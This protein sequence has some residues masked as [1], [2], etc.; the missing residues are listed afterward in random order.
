[1]LRVCGQRLG[2][3]RQPVKQLTR[4]LGVTGQPLHDAGAMQS[5][6]PASRLRPACHRAAELGEG[7]LPGLLLSGGD[8]RPRVHRAGQGDHRGRQSV[9]MDP[10][11]A[12]HVV[13][14]LQRHG[15]ITS[16]SRATPQQPFYRIALGS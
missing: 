14:L 6:E 12:Q 7:A 8:G 1:M 11:T 2:D 15:Q 9:G 4:R 3:L 16:G 10:R 13:D 5:L